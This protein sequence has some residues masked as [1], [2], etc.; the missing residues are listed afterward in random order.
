MNLKDLFK[1]HN[2]KDV[3]SINKD[4]DKQNDETPVIVYVHDF[5]E[6]N[7]VASG[8]ESAYKAKGNIDNYR[9]AIAGILSEY[10]EII[11]KNSFILEEW[12]NKRRVKIETLK[13]ENENYKRSI[14]FLKSNIEE[15]KH[16]ISAA[17]DKIKDILENPKKYEG[18][19]TSRVSYYISI[20]I[21]VFITIYLLVFY[22]SASYS[23]FFKEFTLNDIGIVNAIFD[24][25]A[26]SK[27]M[28][29]GITELIL[30]L[31]IPF[32]FLGL[33]Y[34][35]HKFNEKKNLI[36]YLKSFV[37]IIITFIFDSI[38]A[39][40]IT[41]KIYSVKRDNDFTASMPPYSLSLAFHSVQ[42]WLIIFSGFL[43][44]L[45]WGFVFDFFME[46]HN[47]LDH[48]KQLIKI[49]K[50]E[51][52]KLNT[53]IDEERK[54]IEELNK[55]IHDNEILIRGIEEK[56]NN[57]RTI[58][59]ADKVENVILQFTNGYIN[60]LTRT[61]RHIDAE[62]TRKIAEEFIAVNIRPY[63]EEES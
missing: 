22:S 55:K 46:A 40:E 28:K 51:I 17:N 3:D 34:L 50:E 41:E 36:G 14:E 32:V 58:V 29:D 45:I 11:N 7:W 59:Y 16:K 12:R 63:V 26:F 4:S 56:I 6:R 2:N 30:I 18:E 20:I 31:T 25:S 49:E 13:Q 37:L 1:N 35:I 60:Y 19:K 52:K 27:A 57:K 21:L 38:L 24:A 9:I 33:G 47:N 62:T 10:K 53:L 44:Y 15:L 8:D 23:A 5:F 43:V 48:L 61:N 42:F 39:Y 54:K